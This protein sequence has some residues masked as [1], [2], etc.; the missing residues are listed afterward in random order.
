M[1][2]NQGPGIALGLSFFEDICQAIEEEISV[3]VVAEKL[4]SFDSPG[5]DL[6]EKAGGV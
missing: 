5:H 1:V 3:L 2:W 6:L 4:S